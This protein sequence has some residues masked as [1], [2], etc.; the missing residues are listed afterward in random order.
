MSG[1]QLNLIPDVKAR[2]LK[3]ER[4]RKTAI[5]ISAIVIAASVGLVLVMLSLVA[6][7]KALLSAADKDIDKLS[8]EIK[9]TKDIEKILTVQSQ[10]N[11][12]DKL[13]GEKTLN[14]RLFDYL[15]K[16]V[17]SQVQISTI[18][19]KFED[20]I[21]AISGTADSIETVNK[22]VDTLKFTNF[23]VNGSEEES[24]AFSEVVLKSFGKSDKG[25][26]F[27]IEFK[28][29][30]AL[31]STDSDGVTLVTKQVVTTREQVPSVL[32]NKPAEDNQ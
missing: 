16:L 13:H 18:E 10:L 15:T 23:K 4:T 24:T 6:G 22:F 1:I 26:S 21:A 9:N 32:F 8:S 19:L 14:S 30:P 17:P 7:Q 11:T 5:V 29:N 31:F 2:Y 12:L 3:A 25:T 20:N 28:Y 27:T